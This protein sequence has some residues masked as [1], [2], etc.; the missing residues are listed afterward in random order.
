MF[1]MLCW[2]KVLVVTLLLTTL[3]E[4]CSN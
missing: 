2:I 1:Q 3:L 4:H